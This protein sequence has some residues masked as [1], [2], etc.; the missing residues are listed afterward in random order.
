MH[1]TKQSIEFS[2]ALHTLKMASSVTVT[3]CKRS[4]APTAQLQYR[5]GR[6]PATGRWFKTFPHLFRGGGGLRFSENAGSSFRHNVANG[7]P[8]CME[9][10]T[11]RQKWISI[12]TFERSQKKKGCKN[13][14]IGFAMRFHL[15]LKRFRKVHESFIIAK[16]CRHDTVLINTG[17]QWSTLH[18]KTYSVTVHLQR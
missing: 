5:C 1:F 10:H 17:Q 4:T 3:Y 9:S 14:A 7:L 11:R 2:Q 18:T 15:Y 6:Y 8:D 16:I 13:P 12:V